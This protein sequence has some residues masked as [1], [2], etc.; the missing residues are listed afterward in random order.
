MI[1]E[2]VATDLADKIIG[3]AKDRYEKLHD[4]ITMVGIDE[5]FSLVPPVKGVYDVKVTPAGIMS[6]GGV[7]LGAATLA[8]IH[9]LIVEIRANKDKVPQ[10]VRALN[11]WLW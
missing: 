3:I 10:W 7:I 6:V 9:K 8:L 11:F 1:K 5:D 2:K 4:K